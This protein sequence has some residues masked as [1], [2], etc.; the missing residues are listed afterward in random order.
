MIG[1]KA[2]NKRL[3][4]P[5]TLTAVLLLA[6]ALRLYGIRW[7]LPDVSHPGYSFHPDEAFHLLWARMMVAGE[8]IGKH[9][10]YGGTFYYTILNAY[11]FFADRLGESLDGFNHLASSILLGRYFHTAIALLTILIVY[12]CGRAFYGRKIGMLAAMVLAVAPGHI[13]CAQ[14]MRPDEFAAFLAALIIL[15]SWQ[16]SSS[17]QGKKLRYYLFAGL[18]LGLAIA[19]RF[20]LVTLIGAPLA[21]HVFG[22][23]GKNIADR[24]WSLWDRRVAIMFVAVIVGYAIASPHTFIYPE[25]LIQ[26]I[27]KQWWYQ[28]NPFMDAVDNGPGI[29]QYGWTMLHEALGYPLYFLALGGVVLALVR[30]SQAD[31]VILAAGAP[32]FILTTFT[33]W[34]VVRYT[35]P[36]LPLLAILAGRFVAYTMEKIPRHK[37]VTNVVIAVILAWTLLA[38]YAYLKME[39]E[40]DV[41]DV[42]SEWIQRNL[43]LGSS[44]LIV[45]A[46]LEDDFFNPVL[47][48]GYG[49]SAFLLAKE[50][51][52]QALFRD[53]KFDYLIL[54]EFTY[55]NMERLG[56]RNPHQHERVFH[57]SLL[58]SRYK[59]IKEFKQPIE[60]MGIDFS[61][62]FTSQDY[63]IA[64]PEIRIYRYQG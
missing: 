36:L 20:P 64:N 42:A 30:R 56:P 63:A 51:N 35:L 44:I 14:R 61:S 2:I 37:T 9:F 12:E 7:G 50:N 26:G 4:I 38:D 8:I 17:D 33:S 40:K 31:I 11:Y 41:R 54:H 48:K 47:P 43:P 5:V 57:A 55:K 22:G 3:A 60:A 19:L 53:Y 10:M 39:T 15:L 28:S 59:R 21:V 52:S 27:K 23:E 62:W 13:V 16:I 32:Y 29:Y 18:T 46:Y 1:L 58:N 49:V 24:L 6:L 45:T 25:W 34:V